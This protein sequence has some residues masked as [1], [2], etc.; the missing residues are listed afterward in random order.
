VQA[1]CKLPYQ[2]QPLVNLKT[3]DTEHFEALIRFKA[4]ESPYEMIVFGEDVGLAADLD[5]AVCK[6]LAH[7]MKV[8]NPNKSLK[9][10]MN[11]SGQS[12]QNDQFFAELISI[13]Q[14]HSSTLKKRLLFEIT[15]ST[16]ITDL[17]KVNRYIQILQKLGH[18][19]CLDDFGAGATSFQYLQFL[20][21][22]YVKIDG[23]YNVMESERIATMVKSLV[24]MCHDLKI[25]TVA[26]RVETQEHA[27]LLKQLDVDFGQGYFFAPP[28]QDPMNVKTFV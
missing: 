9:I 6:K 8:K 26:E 2:D 13:L 11:I 4:K 23:A 20:D 18:S 25:K 19:V 28:S 7:Y 24:Q 21:V 27:R 15:E 10:A 14:E 17:D 12:M 5:M 16:K 3:G 1:S 22:N